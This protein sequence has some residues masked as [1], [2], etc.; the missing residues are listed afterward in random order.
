MQ[1][2]K[3]PRPKFKVGQIVMFDRG[4]KRGIPLKILE[5]INDDEFG[6]AY[7]VDKRNYLAESMIRA[8]TDEEKSN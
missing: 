2:A 6:V 7:R 3:T 4:K 8:L 5:V 1:E